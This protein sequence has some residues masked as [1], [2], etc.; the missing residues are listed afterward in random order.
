MDMP[1]NKKPLL[2][3]FNLW[4]YQLVVVVFL[5]LSI[6][7]LF[8]TVFLVKTTNLS[9]PA[10]LSAEQAATEAIAKRQEELAQL[11]QEYR[12]RDLNEKH[13]QQK[14]AYIDEIS[15]EKEIIL[16][17]QTYHYYFQLLEASS[18][19]KCG[20]SY[21]SGRLALV[22]NERVAAEQVADRKSVV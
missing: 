18:T 21:L 5:I 10:S 6:L 1:I 16:S 9:L 13:Q 22:L 17:G 3:K 8:L 20:S 4:Y 14:Q 11:Y 12:D 19:A 2:S 7:G 15:Q